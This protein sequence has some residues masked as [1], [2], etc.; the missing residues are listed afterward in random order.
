MSFPTRALAAAAALPLAWIASCAVPAPPAASPE[1]AFGHLPP[2]RLDAAEVEIVETYR[3][4]LRAPHVEHRFPLTPLAAMRRWAVDRIEAAGETRRVRFVI[5]DA[6]VVAVPLKVREGLRGLLRREQEVRYDAAF[7]AR[8]EVG[9][10]R[11]R[12]ESF[13]TARVV[14]SR[15]APEDMTLAERDRLFLEMTAD[16]MKELNS[17]LEANIRRHMRKDL[18]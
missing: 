18:L 8:V 10:E 16:V 2:I 9:T 11:G 13:A 12:R 7:E 14:R 4:P 3:P 15:T 1:L 17:V 6:R 5:A